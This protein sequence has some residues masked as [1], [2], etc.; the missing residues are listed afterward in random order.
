MQ[1]NNL[2]LSVSTEVLEKM[3]EIAAC[4]IEGVKALSKKS[5]LKTMNPFK[6]VKVDVL[7]GTVSVNVFIVIEKTAKLREVVAAVQENI[8]DK[9][10]TMTGTAVTKVNVTVDDI[11]EEVKED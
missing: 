2:E 3:A 4:E 10:Q 6:G 5:A 8:K 11:C 7:N 9:I 1:D